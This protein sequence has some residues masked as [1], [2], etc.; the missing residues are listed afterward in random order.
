MSAKF[1]NT[2]ADYLEW[3]SAMNLIRNLYNDENY[4]ISLLVSFGC[5]FG[6]RISDILSLKWE[7]IYDKNEFEMIEMKTKKNRII[8]INS[9]HKKHIFDC[10]QRIMP[11]SLN[12]YIFISQKGSVY[13][14]QR[15]NVILK[16]LKVR[17][18]LKVKNFSS[19]SLRK[20][21]G[22]EI[23]NRSGEN[24]ELSI[25]KLSHLFNHSSPSITRRYLGIS[26]KELL[27]TYD[28]LTF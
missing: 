10:Y 24:A 19:H 16:D 13:S 25:V 1:S 11:K 20:C 6:L 7:T 8:K 23:F 18:N 3:S 9:Q 15:I 14:I 22:R 4:K 28:V 21:F 5:F 26:Q 12:E 27:D 2:T 17:Y